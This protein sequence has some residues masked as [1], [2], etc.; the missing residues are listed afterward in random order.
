M[1]RAPNVAELPYDEPLETA[2]AIGERLSLHQTENLIVTH[3]KCR[4]FESRG[5][6]ARTCRHIA[7]AHTA[8]IKALGD[9]R[10][11]AGRRRGPHR[12]RGGNR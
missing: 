10:A 5:W 4:P 8:R 11:R 9:R 1:F 12:N 7:P 2:F 6:I 3:N